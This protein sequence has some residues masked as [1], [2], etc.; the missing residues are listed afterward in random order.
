MHADVMNNV[1][2]CNSCHA[3]LNVFVVHRHGRRRSSSGRLASVRSLESTADDGR[4][5]T[6]R[7]MSHG[8]SDPLPIENCEELSAR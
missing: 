8:A 3:S 5:Q 2:S 4:C 1:Y 7:F 6:R